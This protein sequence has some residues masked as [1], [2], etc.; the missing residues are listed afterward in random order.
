[1]PIAKQVVDQHGGRIEIDTEIDK[2]TT[3]N[4]YLPAKP[5]G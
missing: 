2:G 3:F 1:M 5:V 4:I